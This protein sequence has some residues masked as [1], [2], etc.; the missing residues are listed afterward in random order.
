[1]LPKTFDPTGTY[2]K[3][4]LDRACAFRLMAH[5]E[6]E[7]YL[8]QIVIETANK[9]FDAWEQRGLITKPLLA[10]VAYVDVHL[11]VIALTKSGE[12]PPDLATRVEKCKNR[13]NTYVNTS[14]HGVKEENIL[15][16]LLPVGISGS[17][18]DQTWLLTTSSFGRLRGEVA[19]VSN[20]VYNP[21]D[22][23]NEFD[24]VTQVI[25]GLSDIDETLV[26]LQSL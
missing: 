13:F 7:W 1:M 2:A 26:K 19:H 16:L 9:A 6:I 11:G 4:Q 22:P 5:A 12:A 15:K 14:N 23:K 17:D 24:I 25:E 3:R 21:P 10:L 8:E 20:Q 18:I